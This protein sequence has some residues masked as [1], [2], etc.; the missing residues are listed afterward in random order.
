[1]KKRA[2]IV[3]PIAFSLL[4]GLGACG[5]QGQGGNP[6]T[7]KVT[8][9][10][11]IDTENVKKDYFVGED[12]TSYGLKVY[13]VMSCAGFLLDKIA[14]LKTANNTITTTQPILPKG[15]KSL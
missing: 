11:R 4:V 13:L 1:M 5:N 9:S 2:L 7:D 15:V 3:A 12:F 14:Q 6:T 8:K 10:L